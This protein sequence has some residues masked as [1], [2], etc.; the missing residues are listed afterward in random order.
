MNRRLKNRLTSPLLNEIGLAL[1]ASMLLLLV[2]ATSTAILSRGAAIQL[3][4][5]KTQEITD[6]MFYVVEGALHDQFRQM[7]VM[8]EGWK[9]LATIADR[10]SVYSSYQPGAYASTNGIPSCTG[11][12]CLRSLYPAGGGLLK[13]LGPLW[14]EGQNV[15]TSSAIDGQFDPHTPPDEYDVNL[16]STPAYTQVERLERVLS[17]ADAVGANLSTQG[18]VLGNSES[19]RFRVT[20]Y[21]AKTLK[22]RMGQTV[23][24]TV[25]EMPAV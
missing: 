6:S 20:G 21:T 5:A 9:A 13:N 22:S 11:I 23:I 12:G 19:V 4:T 8:P 2:I 16:S 25:I 18:L 15:D 7:M 14:T 10:P 17:P 3:S 24:V 1:P